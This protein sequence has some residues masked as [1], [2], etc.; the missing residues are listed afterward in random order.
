MRI[1]SLIRLFETL[2]YILSRAELEYRFFKETAFYSAFSSHAYGSSVP[3]SS[4]LSSLTSE[5]LKAPTHI[6]C[7]AY[8]IGFML[9]TRKIKISLAL[10][11]LMLIWYEENCWHLSL[12]IAC[13]KVNLYICICVCVLKMLFFHFCCRS[14]ILFNGFNNECN[15]ITLEIPLVSTI[16]D[17]I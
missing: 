14:S 13:K 15:S 3:V 8:C 16:L 4:F 2:L 17:T 1:R 12:E 11:W 5:P 7:S 6:M 10:A 9:V